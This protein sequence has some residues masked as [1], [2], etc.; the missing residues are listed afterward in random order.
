[1]SPHCYYRYQYPS[2]SILIRSYMGMYKKQD[3][4]VLSIIECYWCSNRLAAWH[5]RSSSIIIKATS[6]VNFSVSVDVTQAEAYTSTAATKPHL[7]FHY[8]NLKV[9]S[10]EEKQQLH[11]KLYAE[12]E[13]MMSR[14]QELFSS[15]TD[16]LRKQNI[17]VRELARNLEC[18]GQI[19]PT[20]KDSNEPVF[21]GQLS[22]LKRTE[23]IDD[24]M[25]VVNNYCSFF[26][27]PVILRRLTC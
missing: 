2:V 24:A 7:T 27:P 6:S 19:K 1:M 22:G 11:Q 21:R 5:K 26:K 20:F 10:K 4:L 3:S 17:P 13:D 23:S 12:S 9:M 14:F 8:L 18:L 25:S 16:S 15:T